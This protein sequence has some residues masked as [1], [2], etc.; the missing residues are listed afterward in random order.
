MKD[1]ASCLSMT[2]DLIA[3]G[4]CI[5]VHDS[6]RLL[7]LVR[8]RQSDANEVQ[9]GIVVPAPSDL[10]QALS[11]ASDPRLSCRPVTT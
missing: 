8:V 7:I 5:F 2:C 3:S 10:S 11:D 1:S 6:Y 4:S 9:N